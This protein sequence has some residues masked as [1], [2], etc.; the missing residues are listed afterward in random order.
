[1]GR[2]SVAALSCVVSNIDNRPRAPDDLLPEEQEIW[3]RIVSS[4]PADQFKTVALQLL[5]AEVCRHTATARRLTGQVHRATD[6]G[7]NL[8]YQ[9]VD[10]LLRGRDRETKAMADKMTKLRLTNQS[11][12]TPQAAATAAKNAGGERKLWQRNT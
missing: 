7:S 8:S 12:Y 2:K 5:L 9:D 3:D 6:E 4:E 10:A 1:M 11:R